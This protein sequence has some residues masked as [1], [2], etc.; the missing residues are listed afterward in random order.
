MVTTDSVRMIR[1]QTEH[2]VAVPT[3][4]S[5]LLGRLAAWLPGGLYSWLPGC[6]GQPGSQS[7]HRLLLQQR[8]DRREP[9]LPPSIAASFH[10]YS[11]PIRNQRV[12]PLSSTILLETY[13]A[14]G[15]C[16]LLLGFPSILRTLHA[17]S[18][19]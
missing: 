12:R 19:S 17:F 9:W 16:S 13:I 14:L 11:I 3:G 18:E 1:V 4:V 10:I 2:T 6:G 7:V 5:L 15:F 8:P